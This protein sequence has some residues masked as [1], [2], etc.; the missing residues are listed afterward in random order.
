MLRHCCCCRCFKWNVNLGKGRVSKPNVF[1]SNGERSGLELKLLVFLINTVVSVKAEGWWAPLWDY[2]PFCQ[3]TT[4][5]RGEHCSL[6]AHRSLKLRGPHSRQVLVCIFGGESIKL[7]IS[8][9]MEV[10]GEGGELRHRPCGNLPSHLLREWQL[11]FEQVPSSPRAYLFN[12]CT[13]S[14]L[15]GPCILS[16][17]STYRVLEDSLK[18]HADSWSYF[19]VLTKGYHLTRR[20]TSGCQQTWKMKIGTVFKKENARNHIWLSEFLNLI[21]YF[22]SIDKGKYQGTIIKESISHWFI[23]TSIFFNG[24]GRIIQCVRYFLLAVTGS[25]VQDHVYSWLLS[26]VGSYKTKLTISSHK[27]KGKRLEKSSL[28]HTHISTM[29]Y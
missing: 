23:I 17:L 29:S 22:T 7:T 21:K 19:H 26:H 1:S 4:A 11:R 16:Y 20:H 10:V 12:C 8:L 27:H 9:I 5:P 14:S 28:K 18:A 3:T 6:K 25:L 24:A 2:T 15:A 13:I